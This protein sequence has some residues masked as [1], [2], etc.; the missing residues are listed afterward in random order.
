MRKMMMTRERK[1]RKQQ[2]GERMKEE[3]EQWEMSRDVL[4]PASLALAAMMAVVATIETAV[5]VAVAA[6]MTA[7]ELLLKTRK[8]RRTL[9]ATIPSHFTLE[10]KAVLVTAAAP[11][12]AVAAAAIKA[13]TMVHWCLS[14]LLWWW[15][16]MGFGA[17]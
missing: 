1:M 15:G 9:L 13:T 12:Q 11:A 17:R 14:R 4:L 2:K 10:L 6:V 3:K 16:L 7:V 8:K 5:A